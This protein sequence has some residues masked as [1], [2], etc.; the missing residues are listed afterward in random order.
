MGNES[1]TAE[2][3]SRVMDVSV[4]AEGSQG[5]VPTS[6]TQ[7]RRPFLKAHVCPEMKCQI[8]VTTAIINIY[9]K[10]TVSQSVTREF[11]WSVTLTRIVGDKMFTFQMGK[12]G[13]KEVK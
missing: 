13:I 4:H 7:K 6:D 11:I 1:C 8:A 2:K 10:H 9:L 5:S 3:T 12:L